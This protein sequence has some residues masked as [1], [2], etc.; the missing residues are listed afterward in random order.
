LGITRVY[1]LAGGFEAWRAHGFPLES[2]TVLPG[3]RQA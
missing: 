3:L 2:K 1:P